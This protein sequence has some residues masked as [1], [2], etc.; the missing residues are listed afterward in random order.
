[1][2]TTTDDNVQKGNLHKLIIPQPPT[3]KKKM[4]ANGVV[5]GRGRG[6]TDTVAAGNF[7]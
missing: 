4:L 5:E 1:L 3:P 2:K 7:E 6:P